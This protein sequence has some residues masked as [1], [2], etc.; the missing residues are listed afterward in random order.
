MKE[1]CLNQ[2]LFSPP[3][4]NRMERQDLLQTGKTKYCFVNRLVIHMK[5]TI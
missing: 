3:W 2:N 5:I 4:N 1:V